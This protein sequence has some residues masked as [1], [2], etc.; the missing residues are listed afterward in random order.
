MKLFSQKLLVMI[1]WENTVR[2]QNNNSVLLGKE[3]ILLVLRVER[4]Q[5][6]D[7]LCNIY[8]FG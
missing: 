5:E 1:E 8:I 4:I 6:S 7:L 3:T 2:A